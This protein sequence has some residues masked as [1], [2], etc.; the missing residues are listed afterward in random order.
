MNLFEPAS[1]RKSISWQLGVFVV[2][3]AV[4]GIGR[5]LHADPAGHGTHQELGLPPCPA[6]LFLN[7]PCPGCGLTTS[8]T[9]LLHGQWAFAFHAHPL[10][11]VLYLLFTCAAMLSVY[12]FARGLRLNI[13]GPGMNRF[14]GT[15]AVIFIAFG[16]TRM[17]LTTDYRSDVEKMYAQEMGIAKAP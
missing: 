4:T 14:L 10:G 13:D 5:F 2:W 12:G 9:A 8:W 16:L 11:P 17:A 7:R 3:T 15:C 6:A 1:H